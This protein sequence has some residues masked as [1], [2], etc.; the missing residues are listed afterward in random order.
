MVLASFLFVRTHV[1]S[2]RQE[3][4]EHDD[5]H[6]ENG[7]V[8]QG[9]ERLVTLRMLPSQRGIH[10]ARNCQKYPLTGLIC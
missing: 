8:M 5:E 2:N 9:H 10:V 7:D 3:Q 1:T 6:T 4:T